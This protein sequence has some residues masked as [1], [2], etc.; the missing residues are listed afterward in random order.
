MKSVPYMNGIIID[1]FIKKV[2]F[3]G[4]ICDSPAKAFVLQATQNFHLL[5]VVFKL[6]NIIKIVFV[7]HIVIILLKEHMNHIKIEYI[8]IMEICYLSLLNYQV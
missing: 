3:S 6:E 5:L 2:S 7:I 8:I 1:N 4:F